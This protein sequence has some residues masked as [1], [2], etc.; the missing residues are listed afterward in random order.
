YVVVETGRDLD[1]RGVRLHHLQREFDGGFSQTPAVRNDD[2]TDHVSSPLLPE[3]CCG[4]LEQ[5]RRRCGAGVLVSGAALAQV[6][7][8]TLLRDHGNGGVSALD[9]TLPG[10][11]E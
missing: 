2:D 6:A 7:G 1:R 8:S 3:R 5:Q 9:G 10:R 4:G 11:G